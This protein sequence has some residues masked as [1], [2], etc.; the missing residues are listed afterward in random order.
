MT[1]ENKT[2]KLNNNNRL[3]WNKKKL[4]IKFLFIKNSFAN[5]QVKIQQQLNWIIIFSYVKTGRYF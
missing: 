4:K 1:E 5:F 2:I 3:L